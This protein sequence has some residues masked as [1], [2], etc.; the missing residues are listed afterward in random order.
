MGIAQVV[1]VEGHGVLIELPVEVTDLVLQFRVLSLERDF[2]VTVW[3]D[4]GGREFVAQFG[5]LV[6]DLVRGFFLS[7]LSERA[8]HGVVRVP[9]QPLYLAFRAGSLAVGFHLGQRV[10]D[11]FEHRF[12]GALSLG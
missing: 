10:R 12:G 1:G 8:G 6:V 3:A 5:E 9:G 2:P 11:A 7:V 4:A